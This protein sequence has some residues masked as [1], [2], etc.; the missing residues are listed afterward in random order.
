MH[1]QMLL[2]MTATLAVLSLVEWHS[3]AARAQAG[4]RDPAVLFAQTDAN[5][6]GKISRAEYVAARTARFGELDHNK[7]GAVSKADFPRAA[8]NPQ[9]A[10]RLDAIIGEAD[11]N[12]DG[13]VTRAELNKAPSP[14]F[15]RA[16]TNH[17][18]AVTAA[19]LSALRGAAR[20]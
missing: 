12:K 2:T 16:D 18:G 14:G 11:A 4:K 1:K 9:A 3:N 19:E 13:K 6:D 8:A 17:D 10:A 5:K 7:D 15:D 20:P